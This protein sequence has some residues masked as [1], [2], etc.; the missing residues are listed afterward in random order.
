M[1]VPWHFISTNQYLI[2]TVAQDAE[3]VHGDLTTSNIMIR[4]KEPS[5]GA[6]DDPS[7]SN[8]EVVLIDFGLGMR[9]VPW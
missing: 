9:I 4:R 7:Q 8:W 6:S 2:V 1:T 5:T 3:I